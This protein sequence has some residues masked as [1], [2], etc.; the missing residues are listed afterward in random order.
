MPL[1]LRVLVVDDLM[2]NRESLGLLVRAWGHEVRLAQDGPSAL[3][4]FQSFHPDVILL[5]I[6]L[7]GMSGWEVARQIREQEGW[8]G[9]LVAVT[10]YSQQQDRVISR[11]A[12]IDFHLV[13][14]VEPEQIRRLLA[15]A[16]GRSN[17]SPCRDD[18]GGMD[19]AGR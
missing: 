12:G 18:Q 6:G 19:G 15:W 8:R 16:G 13:K 17:S 3:A 2:D 14:P 4:T 7:P 11:Q 10:G 5:D 9:L 1:P